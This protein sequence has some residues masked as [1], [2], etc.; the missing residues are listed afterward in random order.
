MSRTTQVSSC[1]RG[2]S[3]SRHWERVGPRRGLERILRPGPKPRDAGSTRCCGS[4]PPIAVSSTTGCVI[5]ALCLPF[6][7]DCR[8]SR[9]RHLLTRTIR[10]NPCAE[11]VDNHVNFPFF[12]GIALW[13][14][15]D[16]HGRGTASRPRRR[17][18]CR[19]RRWYP[20]RG[21]RDPR[22]TRGSSSR[23]RT[24]PQPRAWCPPPSAPTRGATKP[25]R[26]GCR[27]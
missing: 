19:S 3:H 16:N 20:R 8:R 10:T 6:V 26:G 22:R 13:T 2:H 15:V 4:P 24:R 14:T 23:R 25:P 21:R 7:N 9:R 12:Q 18:V 17:R 5:T 11:E 1:D 27:R